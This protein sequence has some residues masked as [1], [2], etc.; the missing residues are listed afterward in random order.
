MEVYMAR[1]NMLP[2]KKCA[3]LYVTLAGKTEV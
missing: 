1:T 3:K 2:T